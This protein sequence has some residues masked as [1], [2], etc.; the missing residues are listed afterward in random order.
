MSLNSENFENL[1]FQITNAISGHIDGSKPLTREHWLYN[2]GRCN[3]ARGFAA[4]LGANQLEADF[5]NHY[6]RIMAIVDSL[7]SE[8]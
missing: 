3:V 6:Q 1:D 4:S 8:G 5:N 2:L 7:K